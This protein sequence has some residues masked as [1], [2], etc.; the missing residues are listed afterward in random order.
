[1]NHYDNNGHKPDTAVPVCLEVLIHTTIM[2]IKRHS[3]KVSWADIIIMR[4]NEN[5]N[6]DFD[7][8]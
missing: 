2:V 3:E 4:S 7:K 8:S 6:Y 5:D 1:M